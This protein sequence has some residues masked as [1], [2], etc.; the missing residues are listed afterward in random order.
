MSL[1]KDA[2]RE[3]L[4]PPLGRR[5]ESAITLP[6]I[7]IKPP[8]IHLPLRPPSA[9]R[10]KRSSAKRRQLAAALMCRAATVSRF[11]LLCTFVPGGEGLPSLSATGRDESHHRLGS[12]RQATFF[13]LFSSLSHQPSHQNPRFHHLSRSGEQST[14]ESGGDGGRVGAGLG[15]RRSLNSMALQMIT[16]EY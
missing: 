2:Q 8:F 3:P 12:G 6:L 16:A 1:I 13:F 15:G 11:T 5:S 4:F 9:P 7:S 14:V 10:R